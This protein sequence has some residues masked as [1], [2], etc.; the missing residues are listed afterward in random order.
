[1]NN[2][3]TST[4]A[5]VLDRKNYE[6][7]DKII[8]FIT[9]LGRVGIIAR[10]A[11]KAKSKLAGGIQLF[12]VNDVTYLQGRGGLKILT[13]SRINLFFENIIK[14]YDRMNLGYDFIKLV[15]RNSDSTDSEQWFNILEESLA[16]LNDFSIDKRLIET[17]FYLRFS[18]LI[19]YGLSLHYDNDGNKILPN[20]NYQYNISEKGLS[21]SAKGAV[22]TNHIKLLRVLEANSIAVASRISGVDKIIDQ[23]IE[24]T[25]AHAAI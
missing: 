6:E 18:E 22:T 5:I 7:A 3:F 11:R 13:S 25:R 2:K 1:M 16:S 21:L 12:A 19:G 23:C 10:G 15:Y 17:W 24:I 14:D 8:E 4:K 20:E 9:P